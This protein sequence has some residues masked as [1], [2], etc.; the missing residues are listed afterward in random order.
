MTGSFWRSLFAKKLELQGRKEKKVIDL[1]S[2]HLS[3]AQRC[4]RELGHMV[5]SMEQMNWRLVKEQAE[6][7]SKYESMADDLHRE[8]VIQIAQGAFFA[9]MREDFL[10]LLERVDQIANAS[11]D[12]A[13]VMA[14]APIERRV[15]AYLYEG[16]STIRKL[17]DSIDSCVA[18]LVESVQYLS[19]NAD[20]AVAKSLEVDKAEEETDDIKGELITRISAHRNEV[21][22]LSYLQAKELIFQLDDV[23]DAAEDCSDLVITIVVKAVS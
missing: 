3:M 18:T 12:A 17:V 23:A 13:R 4:V 11:Q 21:E 7:V 19:T 5:S 20:L 14:E 16:D 6:I 2:Q 1:I 15:L 9:G 22:P 10:D 8:A